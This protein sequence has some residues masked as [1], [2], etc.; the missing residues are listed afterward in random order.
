MA[1]LVACLFWV[2]FV[3]FVIRGIFRDPAMGHSGTKVL[4]SDPDADTAES[5]ILHPPVPMPLI[6]RGRSVEDVAADGIKA[7][8]ICLMQE[9][10][11]RNMPDPGQRTR[12]HSAS[13]ES[14]G[15]RS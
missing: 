12:G 3:A 2:L 13:T 6:P 7:A 10:R 11:K 14:D 5:G 15:D 8:T 9:A 4:Y 1:V